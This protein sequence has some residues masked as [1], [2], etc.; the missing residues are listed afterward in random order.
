MAPAAQNTS[1]LYQRSKNCNNF[2]SQRSRSEPISLLWCAY[3]PDVFCVRIL[4]LKANKLT[5]TTPRFKTT[6]M[7]RSI[8]PAR[9]FSSSAVKSQFA[10]MQ[11]LGTVGN[12]TT[13]ETKDGVPFVTYSLAVN[14]YSP[15]TAEEGKTT[16]ADW[17]N[18]SVFDEKHV[19]FFSNH[20]RSG[21]QVY[22]EA[23]V[24]QRTL[25]DESGENKLIVTTLRQTGYDV[26]R[27]PKKLE[28]ESA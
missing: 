12:L 9:T 20:L 1:T 23:D 22:V 25:V 5:D 17:Y 15:L 10:K 16:V 7:L 26:V 13:R 6:K 28:E 24:R 3:V 14:R 21:A 18:I 2:V 19:T 11:L 8:V 4:Q 27:F